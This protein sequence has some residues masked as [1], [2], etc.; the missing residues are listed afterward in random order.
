[1][2][3]KKVVL[4]A[5]MILSA[6]GV[7]KAE[8]SES[9]SIIIGDLNMGGSTR[10]SASFTIEND[11]LVLLAAGPL[12]STSF[13]I[14]SSGNFSMEPEEVGNLMVDISG[15]KESLLSWNTVP[16]AAFYNLYRGLLSQFSPNDIASCLQREIVGTTARDPALPCSGEGF[17]YLVTAVNGY[18]ESLLG[19]GSDGAVRRTQI[20]CP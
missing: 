13:A 19:R 17:R 3:I 2:R 11:A 6:G 9:F 5:V 16:V 10:S 14:E 15:T 20:P 7:L 4:S 12:S 18:G 1:M 8:Q